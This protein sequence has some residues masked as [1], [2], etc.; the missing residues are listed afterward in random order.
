MRE[1]IITFNFRNSNKQDE[2]KKEIQDYFE[3]KIKEPD[4][5][6]TTTTII[7]ETNKIL[8]EKDIEKYGSIFLSNMENKGYT[9]TKFIIGL[10]QDFRYFYE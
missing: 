5:W 1:I 4:K 6:L 3:G 10:L 9:V 2:F 8:N 7:C